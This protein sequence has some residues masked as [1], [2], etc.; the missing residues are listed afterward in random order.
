[1]K[2]MT[3]KIFYSVADV[4]QELGVGERVVQTHCKELNV[5]RVGK[6]SYIIDARMAIKLKDVIHKTA[7]RPKEGV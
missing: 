2:S 5:P 1:M 4:A 3:N 7:G 6:K